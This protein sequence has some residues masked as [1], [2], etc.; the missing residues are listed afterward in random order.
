MKQFYRVTSAGAELPFSLDGSEPFVDHVAN[1]SFWHDYVIGQVEPSVN[2]E[3]YVQIAESPALSY[4]LDPHRIHCDTDHAHQGI[5]FANHYLEQRRQAGGAYTIHGNV[6]SSPHAEY[7]AALIGGVSG[8]GKSTLS[9]LALEQGWEWVSDE[10]FL[11]DERGNFVQGLATTLQ[12]EKTQLAIGACTPTYQPAQRPIDAFVFPIVSAQAL[13]VH[14]YDQ[15]KAYWHLY[16]EMSRNIT[17]SRGTLHGYMP[18]MSADQPNIAW[19]RARTAE[20]LSNRLPMYF[21]MGQ[22]QAILEQIAALEQ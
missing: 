16:E 3:E 19:R 15:G 8:I 18:L 22:S 21:M 20:L 12:D 1:H 4:S 11:L 14:H 6:I 2:T 17:A 7:T 5:K 9:A 13:E 10:K